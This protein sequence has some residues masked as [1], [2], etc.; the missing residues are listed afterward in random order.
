MLERPFCFP[1]TNRR[2]RFH[3]HAIQQPPDIRDLRDAEHVL[4]ESLSFGP[5]HS[6]LRQNTFSTHVCSSST[7]RVNDTSRWFFSQTADPQ[8]LPLPTCRYTTTGLSISTLTCSTIESIAPRK[9]WLPTVEY[10]TNQ[11]SLSVEG[12]GA[13]PR[14]ASTPYAM[15]QTDLRMFSP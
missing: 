4:R 12:P 1:G 7:T 13:A 5:N 10:P 15:D 2:F 14:R 8:S 9:F 11:V 3:Q 6:Y